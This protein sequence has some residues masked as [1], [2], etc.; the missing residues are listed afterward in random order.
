MNQDNMFDET[1]AFFMESDLYRKLLELHE[2]EAL[3][4]TQSL[5]F[6]KIQSMTAIVAG[7][8][9]AVVKEIESIV[10]K[11]LGDWEALYFTLGFRFA[12]IFTHQ[13][14]NFER[15]VSND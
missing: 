11:Y 8:D 2:T 14:F 7:S 10:F 5:F 3:N 13:L 9:E 1:M 4:N 15:G 6:E 12:V